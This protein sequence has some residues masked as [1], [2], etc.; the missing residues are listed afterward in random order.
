M[1]PAARVAAAIEILDDIFAGVAAEKALTGWGRSHRFAGSK[2]RAAIRD[3]VFQA[4]RCRASYGWLG[5]ADTGRGVMLG[6]MRDAGQ[7]DAMFTGEG[8]APRVVED[9][10]DAR[11][12]M[13][14]DR[15]VQR[16]MPD[17]L[18]PHFDAALGRDADD[19]MDELRNRAGV[20]LRVNAARCD[21]QDAIAM[22]AEDGV[23]AVVV[24]DIKNALQV[25]ENERRVALSHAYTTGV[26]EL[27]DTSSQLFISSLG[28]TPGLRVLDF[29]AGGGG[30]ALAMAALGA[31]VTAHDIDP[32]RM[33]DIAPRAERAG[34]TIET[35]TSDTL[36]DVAPF[37]LVL[38]DAPCSGSGTWRR[39]PAAK[40]ELTQ[41][42]LTELTQIQGDVVQHAATLVRSGGRLAYAT[43]SVLKC[44]NNDIIQRLTG[45]SSSFKLIDETVLRPRALGDGFYFAQVL[46]TD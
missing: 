35:V 11:D 25:V 40:W 43:C 16:D 13:L 46:R 1:Q 44:E 42:R 38:V 26:V 18:L 20:F 24:P 15:C 12:L 19:I 33:T 39:T 2:D 32:R 7:V 10:E 37:D 29:C 27:Q 21:A 4:L 23:V 6:A 17:W 22:L 36:A 8:H 34:V 30:K 41:D 3:H 28:I 31:D 45:G 9:G 14:A 5:G